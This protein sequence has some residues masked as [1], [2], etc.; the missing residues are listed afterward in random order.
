MTQY[1]ALKFE[2]SIMNKTNGKAGNAFLLSTIQTFV[3]L[4][5][6]KLTES[7]S[8]ASFLSKHLSSF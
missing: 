1:F 7:F 3:I 4:L 6:T 8:L 2:I 5:T